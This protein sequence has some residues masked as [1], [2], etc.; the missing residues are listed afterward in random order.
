MKTYS[1]CIKYLLLLGV[2]SVP[3]SAKIRWTADEWNEA[4]KFVRSVGGYHIS[5]G[6]NKLRFGKVF[7]FNPVLNGNCSAQKDDN[8]LCVCLSEAA[9]L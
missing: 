6:I 5:I 7:T 3:L 4:G 2:M 8:K 9:G 1:N